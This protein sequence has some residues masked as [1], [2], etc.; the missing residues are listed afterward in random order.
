MTVELERI[1]RATAELEALL[2]ELDAALSGPYHADQHHA[3]PLD[4]LFE[5]HVR[6]F[7]ARRDGEAV[8]CGGV[9]F[10]DGFAELKR[11]YTRPEMRGRGVAKTML[12]RLEGEARDA[13]LPLLRLETGVYQDAAIGLYKA[14]GFGECPP[15]GPYTELPPHHIETSVF[16]EKPLSGL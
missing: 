16:F 4:A 15:F 3:L 7:L 12:D 8:G 1:E 6:M 9:A 10:Y 5:P 2:G 14:Q 11:M 13:G